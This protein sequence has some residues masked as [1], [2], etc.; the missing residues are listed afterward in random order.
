MR[1]AVSE[2]TSYIYIFGIVMSVL[3]IVFVQVNGMVEDMK[4]SVLSKS[5]EQSFKRIQY[6]VYSVAFGDV[7]SQVA[8][9]ELQGGSMFLSKGPEF[10]VAFV[11]GS[12][13]ISQFDCIYYNLSGFNP[14]CLNLSNGDI[15]DIY[16]SPL[17]LCPWGV[18]DKPACILNTTAGE[19]RYEYKDWLL[20]MEAGA[21]FSKYSNTE[22][23]KLLYEP[24]ILLSTTAGTSKYLVIT[25]PVLEG[26]ISMAGSGR[27]RFTIEE[28]NWSY[29]RIDNI[30]KPA[31]RDKFEDVYIILRGT[32]H[33]QGWCRFFDNFGIFD[34]NLPEINRTCWNAENPIVK[35]MRGDE[36][37]ETIIL[38]K[39][40]ALYS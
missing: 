23:S 16:P 14:R 20:S 36:K 29:A 22:Y 2:V 1:N 26:D 33:Q 34:L 28:R 3:A 38:F 10:I 7:P 35:I 27:F 11:N 39:E 40:V 12:N 37:L 18:Y 32:Q 31:L 9:I 19:L 6:I 25:I 4:R 15:Y 5:L 30:N 13:T 17:N 8:E 21:I 24:R